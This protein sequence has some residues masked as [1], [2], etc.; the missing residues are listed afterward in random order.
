M[1]S[2]I[3]F[4]KPT[5]HQ[6]RTDVHVEIVYITCQIAYFNSFRDTIQLTLHQGVEQSEQNPASI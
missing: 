3:K 5:G 4:Q 2:V 1:C 6:H